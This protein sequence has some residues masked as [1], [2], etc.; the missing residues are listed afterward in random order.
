M[1][2]QQGKRVAIWGTAADDEKVSVS[3]Q[4]Q[5]VSRRTK[6]GRW[7]VH[8]ENLK[9][10]GPFPM[11]IAGSNT[12]RFHSVLVGEVWLASGQSNM[13][14][15]ISHSHVP[16]EVVAQA[17][18]PKIRIF[19]VPFRPMERRS[20]RTGL[21]STTDR[22]MVPPITAHPARVRLIRS[23]PIGRAIFARDLQKARRPVGLI[24]DS[25]GDGRGSLMS[26]ASTPIPACELD[27]LENHRRRGQVSGTGKAQRPCQP[28]TRARTSSGPPHPPTPCRQQLPRFL[29]F[30]A[31]HLLQRHVVAGKARCASAAH[32]VSG[33]IE[34]RQVVSVQEAFPGHDPE[35]RELAAEVLPVCAARSVH[36]DRQ[37]LTESAGR[38]AS[39]RPTR[40]PCR[41]GDGGHHCVGDEKDIH[42]REGCRA[43]VSPLPQGYRLRR[44]H[45]Y[46][47]PVYDQMRSKAA[48]RSRSD[49]PAALRSAKA[50][51]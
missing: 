8:L 38:L 14:W 19:T 5:E 51:R 15:P 30:L 12:I 33:R 46:L 40:W 47:G 20:R 50:A 36:E 48:D 1:V 4:G 17:G 10:G 25:T 42:P 39:A 24:L 23:R 27:A 26:R 32:L 22:A 29:G 9:A 2:L 21:L 34:F 6:N 13:V 35:R 11:T 37:E 44:E 31:L 3:F 41:H 28:V 7:T 45:Q 18:N 43:L 16:P 49:T